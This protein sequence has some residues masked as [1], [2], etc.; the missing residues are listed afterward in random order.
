MEGTCLLET[1]YLHESEKIIVFIPFSF[2]LTNFPTS[3]IIWLSP[4]A[5][6]R[7]VS[8]WKINRYED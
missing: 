2:N 7:C 6:K 3:Y 4:A 1:L 8:A 5:M